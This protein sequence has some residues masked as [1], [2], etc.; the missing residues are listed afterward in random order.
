M[1]SFNKKDNFSSIGIIIYYYLRF[2]LY[3]LKFRYNA[4]NNQII[5]GN[6]SLEA[7]LSSLYII[8]KSLN[9]NNINNIRSYNANFIL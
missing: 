9:V 8:K 1:K 6:K 2:N 5:Y 7:I 4:K 3:I